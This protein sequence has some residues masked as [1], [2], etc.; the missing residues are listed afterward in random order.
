MIWKFW[1]IL[2]FR[3]QRRPDPATELA[4]FIDKLGDQVSLFVR[5]GSASGMPRGLDW[6]S[7]DP[8]GQP[9][10]A[11]N[12][13]NQLVI[14]LPLMIQFEP[15]QDSELADVPQAREPRR[16]TAIFYKNGSEWQT[17][18]KPIFNLSPDQVVSR[19]QGQY[20]PIELDK[21]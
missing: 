11:W 10:L 9:Q 2:N 4:A 20:E 7:A 13:G 21:Q 1:S 15:Q 16:V 12:N 18:G 6:L 14:L 17:N 19:S 8:V 5:T 3:G